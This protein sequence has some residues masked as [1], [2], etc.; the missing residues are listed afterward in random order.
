MDFYYYSLFLVFTVIAVMV[1]L[2]PNV[3]DYIILLT[4]VL[5]LNFERF[6]WM[7]RFHPKNPVGRYLM[8]RRSLK[9]AKELQKE[10]DKNKNE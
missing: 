8:W 3:G 4:K 10:F 1:V 7:I 9:L 2:D 5:K 6:I